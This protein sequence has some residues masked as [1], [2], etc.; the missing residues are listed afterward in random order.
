LLLSSEQAPQM[1]AAAL[2]VV[3]LLFCSVGVCNHTFTP[4]IRQRMG[5]RMREGEGRQSGT[6]SSEGC[7]CHSL[8][9]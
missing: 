1:L 3:Q 4:R 5:L 7:A 2:S 9:T 6:Q 8:H